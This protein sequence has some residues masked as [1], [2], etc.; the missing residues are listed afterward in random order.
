MTKLKH[1]IKLLAVAVLLVLTSNVFALE[2]EIARDVNAYFALDYTRPMPANPQDTSKPEQFTVTN[3]SR[4]ATI[5]FF[6]LE[7]GLSL[8]FYVREN[9]RSGSILAPGGTHIIDI[10]YSAGATQIQVVTRTHSVRYSPTVNGLEEVTDS[11]VTGF[12][13]LATDDE[14]HAVIVTNT[15]TNSAFNMPLEGWLLDYDGTGRNA[16]CNDS[17]MVNS[18]DVFAV[19]L[20]LLRILRPD[21]P[22]IDE[23]V[24]PINAIAD[25]TDVSANLVTPF[26]LDR[27]FGA[28]GGCY[29]FVRNDNRLYRVTLDESDDTSVALWRIEWLDSE[30]GELLGTYLIDAPEAIAEET[31]TMQSSVQFGVSYNWDTEQNDVS[32]RWLDANMPD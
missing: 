21:T 29:S 26:L 14:C 32:I 23:T 27:A 2:L 31:N 13:V 24:P 16:D 6:V 3:Q 17:E 15:S 20:D 8:S 9:G 18:D 1:L 7:D 12:L 22:V 19:Y 30:T 10:E 25:C 5:D 11:L 4:T 28:N